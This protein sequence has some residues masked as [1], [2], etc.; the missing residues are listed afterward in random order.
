LNDR[1]HAAPET[2]AFALGAT[3]RARRAPIRVLYCG[4]AGQATSSASAMSP[5][6]C[7]PYRDHRSPVESHFRR[8]D[9]C[10]GRT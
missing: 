6:S 9:G 8:P 4:Q 10:A 2:A 7:V 5:L 3:A 1:C